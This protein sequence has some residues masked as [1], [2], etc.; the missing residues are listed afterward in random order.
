MC[1]IYDILG[2]YTQLPQIVPQR[3][4]CHQRTEY[5]PESHSKSVDHAQQRCS[6]QV[7]RP[8]PTKML[9]LYTTS[10]IRRRPVFL[11]LFRPSH[12]SFSVG[13]RSVKGSNK[14]RLLVLI[15]DT[16]ITILVLI[17]SF[18]GPKKCGC[19]GTSLRLLLDQLLSTRNLVPVPQSAY[20]RCNLTTCNL[21]RRDSCQRI[22]NAFLRAQRCRHYTTV[23]RNRTRTRV[24]LTTGQLVPGSIIPGVYN[25]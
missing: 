24:E 8:C 13:G 9:Y 5:A 11:G 14:P 23:V 10:V 21:Q 3:A 17:A 18:D 1:N 22:F 12:T 19:T 2:Y 20:C 16:G 7:S 4:R 6:Q 25:M 15:L